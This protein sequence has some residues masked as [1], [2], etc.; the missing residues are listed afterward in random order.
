MAQIR[1]GWADAVAQ[2]WNAG[3]RSVGGV[4]RVPLQ[5]LT[6][7]NQDPARDPATGESAAGRAVLCLPATLDVLQP[8]DVLVHLHGHNIGYRQR[9]ASKLPDAGTVR[10]VLIDQIEDQLGRAKRP[11]LGVLPQGTVAPAFG[12]SGVAGFDCNTFLDE[13]LNAAVAAGIWKTAPAVARVVLSGHGAGGD[14]IGAIVGQPGQPRLPHKL[15]GLFLFEAIDRPEVLASVTSFLTTRLNYDMLNLQNLDPS[16]SDEENYLR[17]SLKVRAIYDA[18]DATIG[19][20][21]A[22]LKQS[23]VAWFARNADSIGGSESTTYR[24]LA[25]N[26]QVISTPNIAADAMVGSGNLAQALQALDTTA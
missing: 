17:A 9:L 10:D 5:G 21:Y 4:R 18:P 1:V 22:T 7:V 6:L 12:M 19:V 16:E 25:A 23:L 26:Y 8:I 20:N 15:A 2:G 3:E 11:M 13:A 14:T 24:A